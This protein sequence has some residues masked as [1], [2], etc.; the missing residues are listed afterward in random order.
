MSSLEREQSTPFWPRVRY[1]F[2]MSQQ[3][4]IST[5]RPPPFQRASG[6][7]NYLDVVKEKSFDGIKPDEALEE[8]K[9]SEESLIDWTSKSTCDFKDATYLPPRQLNRDFNSFICQPFVTCCCGYSSFGVSSVCQGCFRS[10]HDS[11]GA[12]LQALNNILLPNFTRMAYDRERWNVEGSTKNC[13]GPVVNKHGK[14]VFTGISAERKVNETRN[15][16]FATNEEIVRRV[17][18]TSDQAQ[19]TKLN[20]IKMEGEEYKNRRKF[21]ESSRQKRKLE[22]ITQRE[23]HHDINDKRFKLELDSNKDVGNVKNSWQDLSSTVYID[24]RI[25]PPPKMDFTSKHKDSPIEVP[26]E[27]AVFGSQSRENDVSKKHCHEPN[28]ITSS[29]RISKGVK[30]KS[31]GSQVRDGR[32]QRQHESLD[33]VELLSQE[34]HRP[35]RNKLVTPGRSSRNESGKFISLDSTKSSFLTLMHKLR[36]QSNNEVIA[37]PFCYRIFS[38]Y[39]DLKTHVEV[40][41]ET[42]T[43]AVHN[44]SEERGQRG[45]TSPPQ[46]GRKA[47]TPHF[48]SFESSG[49]ESS[50]RATSVIMFAG[51][52]KD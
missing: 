47:A 8:V 27:P 51:Q 2:D 18:S 35:V 21:L 24:K 14:Y 15:S 32:M 39:S 48:S 37:C 46:S 26:K 49:N 38:K 52:K 22:I 31:G 20:N 19:H 33:D 9:P 6:Y 44:V 34:L 23:K 17:K 5:L 43:S 41:E 42:R 1:P 4:E 40:H 50:K 36:N 30:L 28:T 12:Y 16:S 3:Q 25:N 13:E 10:I 7:L 29:S 11:E 45:E